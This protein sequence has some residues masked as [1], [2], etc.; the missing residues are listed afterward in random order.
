MNDFKF[1]VKMEL[2]GENFYRRQAEININNSLHQV[3]LMLA[4]DEKN[5]ARLLA[6]KLGDLSVFLSETTT[7]DKA[8]NI[9]EGAKDI[10]VDTKETPN[11]L[12]FYRLA[13]KMEK[14]SIDLYTHY[15]ALAEDKKEKVIFE[16]LIK[17]EKIHYEIL[18]TLATLLSRTEE[19]V[20]SAEFGVREEY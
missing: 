16:Y 20:E 8:K 18:D 15:L 2:D 14:E 9:F 13:S 17:Q 6:I 4:E 19:W 3:C 5:H 7:L 11:Q 1:A 12:D 10:A